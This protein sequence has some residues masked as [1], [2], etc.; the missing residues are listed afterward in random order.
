MKCSFEIVKFN[1]ILDM[2]HLV[3][4]R[5]VYGSPGYGIHWVWY[6]CSLTLF[7]CWC[8]FSARKTT[9]TLNILQWHSCLPQVRTLRDGPFNFQEGRE[10]RRIMFFFLKK[11]SDS[12]C[13]WKK[14]SDF[15]GGKKIFDSEFLSY[16]LM[17]NSG[18]KISAP[19]D[20]K[21]YSSSCCP[22]K[23]LWTKQKTIYI[24]ILSY[25]KLFLY[26]NL[27]LNVMLNNL[28]CSFTSI[29]FLTNMFRQHT[30]VKTGS[31]KRCS[32]RVSISCLINGTCLKIIIALLR[33][34][35]EYIFQV[36]IIN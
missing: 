22:E 2:H 16:N 26:L 28:S 21:K 27:C 25:Y 7:S 20:K 33:P 17:L 34:V 29:C 15:G 23:N 4:C 14:Y 32:G 36:H 31:E 8:I 19:R 6:C 13:C 10:G 35:L 9:N 5:L 3:F 11:Y 12:Q 24:H 1:V 30:L 18:K